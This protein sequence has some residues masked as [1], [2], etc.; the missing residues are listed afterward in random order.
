MRNLVQKVF[1][2]HRN[3]PEQVKAVMKAT[4]HV[5]P[6]YTLY[7]SHR[8]IIESP[9]GSFFGDKPIIDRALIQ[10]AILAEGIK[11]QTYSYG[12]LVYS[13]LQ[14]GTGL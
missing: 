4:L 10:T 11:V 9:V 7:R 6:G 14:S 13:T 3:I 8:E 12:A 5:I 2:L 1:D